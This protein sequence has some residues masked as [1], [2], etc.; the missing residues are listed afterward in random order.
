MVAHVNEAPE[1]LR[2]RVRGVPSDVE[3]VVMRCLQKSPAQRYLSARELDEALARC[4]D[5]LASTGERAVVAGALARRNDEA[6]VGRSK[7]LLRMTGDRRED[8]DAKT[9]ERQSVRSKA[10]SR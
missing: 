1:P 9:L 2:R 7:P 5:A 4:G 8:E 3:A 10:K 6:P